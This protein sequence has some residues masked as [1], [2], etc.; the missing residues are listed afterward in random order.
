MVAWAGRSIQA[1]AMTLGRGLAVI[2]TSVALASA[3]SDSVSVTY[4]PGMPIPGRNS[5][6][7]SVSVTRSG[8]WPGSASDIDSYFA[9]VAEIRSKLRNQPVCVGRAPDVPTVSLKI[10]LGGHSNELTCTFFR[11]R[12]QGGDTPSEVAASAEVDRLIELTVKR[13]GAVLVK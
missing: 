8:T 5:E 2:G 12:V 11:G 13:A 4:E 1:L 7:V 10:V 9:S 6:S 3:A